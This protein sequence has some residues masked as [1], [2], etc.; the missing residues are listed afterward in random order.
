MGRSSSSPEMPGSA[1]TSRSLPALLALLG[2]LLLIG[3]GAPRLALAGEYTIHTCE[4][5]EAGYSSA[6][7][8][9][10]AERGMKWRRACD[11]RGPGLRGLVSSNVSGPGRVP[12]GAEAGFIL[13]APPGTTFSGMRWSG[14]AHRRDCRYALQ[15]YAER[16]G[17]TPV[18]IK[19]VRA[20]KHCPRA[21]L[22]QSSNYPLPRAYDLG[23]A[24]RIIQRTVCVGSASREYCSARGQNYIGTVSVEATVVDGIAPTVGVVQ[25]SALARGEWVRGRQSFTYE[26]ADNVGVKGASAIVAGAQRGANSRVCNYTQRIPCPSGPGLIDV[27]TAEI[28]EGSQALT[29]VTEDAAGNRAESGAVTVRIDNA[30]PGAVAIG[31]GGGEGWRNSNDFDLA[32]TNPPEA[33]RAPI[34]AAHYRLCRPDGGDCLGG[35]RDGAGIAG[36]DKVTVPSPGEWELRLWREDAAGNEQIANSSQPVRL[37]FDPEPPQ[38]GF[39]GQSTEDP[40]RVSVLVTDRISGLGSGE[41][42]ISRAGSGTWQILPTSQEGDHLVTRIDDAALPAGDYELRASARDQASNLGGTSQRLDGQPM[43]LTL[44]L[45]VATSMKAGVIGK[46]LVSHKGQKKK[47]RRTVLEPRAKVD[48]GRRVRLGGHLV[49]A[50]G[51]PLAGAK[52][53]VYSQPPEGIEKLEDTITTDPAGRFVYEV[54]ARLSRRFRFVY[55]GTATILP[56]EDEAELLVTATSTLAVKPGHVLNGESVWFSG[57]VRGRPLPE[58]GKLVE[59]QW[60]AGPGEWQTFRTMK[61]KADGTW[62]IQYPFKQTCGTVVFG[63]RVFLQGEAGYPLKPGYSREVTVRVKGRP[64]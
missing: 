31:V 60:S 58:E 33:D 53:Q 11:P 40:T 35:D 15:L 47:V 17:A 26:A 46:R 52:V 48:F 38:L 1:D 23:G 4:A 36:I 55:E 21:G 6:A 64:C 14:H 43:R 3:L 9:V 39:E 56:T 12:R 29:L 49:N 19:N 5:D 13:S 7:F 20:N 57:R 28:P 42:E 25:D 2:A 30:A 34:V 62:R 44:P 61:T 27:N 8:E 16:P 50:S 18:A 54:E 37:R 63:F 32:W 59:L 24:T 10:F 51:H 22:A 41:I 45:R